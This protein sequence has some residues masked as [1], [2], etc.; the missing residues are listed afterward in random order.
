MN[1]TEYNYLGDDGIT[2]LDEVLWVCAGYIPETEVILDW[3]EGGRRIQMDGPAAR[4]IGVD[5]ETVYRWRM[6]GVGQG[7]QLVGHQNLPGLSDALARSPRFL[8]RGPVPGEHTYPYTDFFGLLNDIFGMGL[9][10]VDGSDLDSLAWTIERYGPRY[11]SAPYHL[12]L[13][14]Q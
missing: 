9:A 8:G 14:S 3:L 10:M 11:P 2:H 12:H 4:E 7:I 5:P 13:T 1:V 6:G